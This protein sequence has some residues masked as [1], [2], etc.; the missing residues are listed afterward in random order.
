MGSIPGEAHDDLLQRV[1]ALLGAAGALALP[2]HLCLEVL[3]IERQ[4]TLL[5][6]LAG[7]LHREPVC[8]VE[9]EGH[10]AREHLHP[11]LLRLG[12]GLFHQHQT[13][14]QGAVEPLLLGIGHAE[15][16]VP[17]LHQ[18]RIGSAHEFYSPFRETS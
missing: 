4:A 7:D 3:E 8:V 5:G 10:R 13:L 1:T 12:D 14:V 9:E 16:A 18:L 17:A 15:D 2:L 11:L 6:D